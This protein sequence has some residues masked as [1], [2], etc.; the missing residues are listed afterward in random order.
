MK[1]DIARTTYGINGNGVTIGTLSDSYDCLSG[2]AADVTSGDLPAG[3]NV[4]DDTSCPATDEGRAMMQL[5]TDVAP[6]ANQAFHTASNGQADFANGIL[7][8]ANVAGADI[9]VDDI[10]YLA[11]PFFQDGV[12]SQAVGQV[13]AQGVT[14]F[15]SA[16]NS[17]RRSYE[18]AFRSS[19]LEILFP[20]GDAHDFDPGAG[21]DVFQQITIPIGATAI[22]SL[23]WDQPFASVSGSGST[24]DIDIAFFNADVTA[25]VAASFDDNLYGDPVEVISFENNTASTTF[26][27]LIE[28]F[29]SSVG[30]NPGLLKYVGFRGFTIDEYNTNSSTVVGHAN[31]SQV[32]SVGAA[33][34]NNTPPF[35]TNPP[36]A[37]TF[38]SVGGTPILFDISGNPVYIVRN[39]PD[40]VAPDGTNTTFFGAS[41]PDFDG[42]PNFFGTSAAAPHAAAVAALM[43]EKDNTY[44]P[45]DIITNME[46]TAIDMDVS[47]YDFNT[48]HGLIDAEA[49]LASIDPPPPSA[50]LISP[51]GTITDTTP[52]YTWNAVANSTWYYLWVND[53]TG[54]VIR[55]WYTADQAGCASGT[56][57]CS[58]TPATTLASGNGTWWIQTW[59][60]A[61]YGP[62]SAGMN[63]NIAP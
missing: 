42:F 32:I 13:V 36:I 4:L 49:A 34:Y 33:A 27:L 12:I 48:G 59:N 7:E 6:G 23:Q 54:N 53:S 18:S 43:L 24:N 19:G 60:S 22:I 1:S 31:A 40:I 15:S 30:P 26:Q 21:V 9:I 56:G 39:K 51:N 29:E 47:G 38:S 46:S 16:G 58:V 62:W 17:G 44:S 57:T 20:G 2:A 63:F 41:D 25:I 45:L 37:E 5:I 14:Y 11:E 52:T 28:K 8:L 35:G 3:I 61:G 55:K 10:S 50:T